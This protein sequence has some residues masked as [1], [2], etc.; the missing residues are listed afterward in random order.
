MDTEQSVEFFRTLLPHAFRFIN[1]FHSLPGEFN[2][3]DEDSDDEDC[4]CD[5]DDCHNIPKPDIHHSLPWVLAGRR[6]R[7]L[8]IIGS[9]P[10]GESASGCSR[11]T[12]GF[13][14]RVCDLH[15]QVLS[16]A[17]LSLVDEIQFISVALRKELDMGDYKKWYR[18]MKRRE[19]GHLEDEEEHNGGML[20]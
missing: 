19:E 2:P 10:T 8:A 16:H 9:T 17:I 20:H 18:K 7:K 12:A 11:E 4:D 13:N 5:D 3:T 14:V 6:T 15:W 1:D